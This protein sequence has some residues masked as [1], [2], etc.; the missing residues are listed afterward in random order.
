MPIHKFWREAKT[1]YKVQARDK[2]HALE[3]LKEEED[4]L[5][6]QEFQ[7]RYLDFGEECISDW[8]YMGF[9][10]VDGLEGGDKEK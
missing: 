6:E 10:G 7:D 2:D 4:M 1:I 3:I 8:H 5:E 9:L